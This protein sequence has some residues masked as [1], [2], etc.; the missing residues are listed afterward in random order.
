MVRSKP[1]LDFVRTHFAQ[2]YPLH[3]EQP[4]AIK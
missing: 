3:P 2:A 4:S 1:P